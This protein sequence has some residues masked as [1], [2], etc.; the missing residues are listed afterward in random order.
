MWISPIG[1]CTAF[2]GTPFE[3]EISVWSFENVAKFLPHPVMYSIWNRSFDRGIFNNTSFRP[4]PAATPWW[5]MIC[6]RIGYSIPPSQPRSTGRFFIKSTSKPILLSHI[7]RWVGREKRSPWVI[8][9]PLSKRM[10]HIYGRR[11]DLKRQRID[12]Q[13]PAVTMVCLQRNKS[14]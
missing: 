13:W 14:S 6:F 12:N 1:F 8:D 2:Y 4:K 7:V 5:L 9:I 11:C 10:T 3:K